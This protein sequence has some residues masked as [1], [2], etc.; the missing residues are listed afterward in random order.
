MISKRM[1]PPG[2]EYLAA[3]LA[4]LATDFGM[5]RFWADYSSSDHEWATNVLRL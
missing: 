3:P 4:M 1:S 5:I 2:V